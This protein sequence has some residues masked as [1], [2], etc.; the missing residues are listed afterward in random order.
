MKEWED[1]HTLEGTD[2]QG[3]GSDSTLSWA[4]GRTDHFC[5]AGWT[6]EP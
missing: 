1:G 5:A 2:V 6:P 3:L 4:S